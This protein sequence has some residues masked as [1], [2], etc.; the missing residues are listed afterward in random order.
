MHR[1]CAGC[2]QKVRVQVL[3]RLE[4]GAPVMLSGCWTPCLLRKERD[5]ELATLRRS[6]LYFAALNDS[7]FPLCQLLIT[8]TWHGT[9]ILGFRKALDGTWWMPVL[10]I[11]V[12]C[13]ERN[14]S[15]TV[16]PSF[17]VYCGCDVFVF[18]FLVFCW[19]NLPQGPYR[20]RN[21]RY[22]SS[23][24]ELRSILPAGLRSKVY[25]TKNSI[26]RIDRRDTD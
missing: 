1:V 20:V 23:Y 19:W 17:E 3:R 26:N 6:Q 15:P 14:K 25:C 18:I 9:D 24:K 21:I 10:R 16:R 22:F 2:D 11:S 4:W 13:A 12:W 7:H 5:M 8:S